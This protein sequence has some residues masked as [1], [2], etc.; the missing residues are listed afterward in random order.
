[1]KDELT[2]VEVAVW[3]KFA[4]A[5]ARVSPEAVADRQLASF[6]DW[7]PVVAEFSFHPWQERLP[8]EMHG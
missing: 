8:A 1:V 6:V 2:P 7:I 5:V 4:V 3:T